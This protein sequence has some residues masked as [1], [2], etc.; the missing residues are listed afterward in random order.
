MTIEGET[1]TIR[2][3][4]KFHLESI[5]K[6]Y[7]THVYTSFSA[8]SEEEFQ[9]SDFQKMI[10]DNLP[11]YVVIDKTLSVIGFG[12]TYPYRKEKTFSKSVK[13]TYFLTAEST[14][15]GIGSALYNVMEKQCLALGIENILVN[16]SSENF[17]SI[18]FHKNKG[19]TECGRFKNVGVK[20]KKHFDMVWMIK[21]LVS[22]NT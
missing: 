7:N 18:N 10:D 3:L 16:I 5:V 11:C 15:K 21:I 9:V 1:Y 20:F 8:F 4:E 2:S 14:G 17:G 13:F 12:L 6:I 22:P 19:F